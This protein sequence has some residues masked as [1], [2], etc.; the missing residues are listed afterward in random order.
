MI[1]QP[2]RM[3]S[4]RNKRTAQGV[5]LHQW[6]QMARIAEVIGKSAL[7]HAGT[8][9]RLHGHNARVALALDLAPHIRHRQ[10]GKVRS[11]ARAGDNH[12][13]IVVGQ[14]HLFDRFQANHRLVQQHMIQHAAQRV[15]GVRILRSDF[16]GLGD[17]NAE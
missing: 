14:G 1:A 2:A 12:V 9:R 10:T 11:A 5:H 8:G 6:G 7:G 4:R 17:R 3:N 15:L 13:R 16:H